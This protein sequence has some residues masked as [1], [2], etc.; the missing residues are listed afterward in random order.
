MSTGSVNC[1][2]YNEVGI[3]R[4]NTLSSFPVQA[5]KRPGKGPVKDF[6]RSLKAGGPFSCL[7]KAL[8]KFCL[9]A[10]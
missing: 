3:A 2:A 6:Q 9:K 10:F 1:K 5:L 4:R 8:E 7:S